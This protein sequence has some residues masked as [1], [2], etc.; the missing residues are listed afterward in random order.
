MHTEVPLSPST[1]PILELEENP[2]FSYLHNLAKQE[3]IVFG[4]FLSLL[5][6][7]PQGLAH[8]KLWFLDPFVKQ[9]PDHLSTNPGG[10][11]LCNLL[12]IWS[13]AGVHGGEAEDRTREQKGHWGRWV[14]QVSWVRGFGA[15][16]WRSVNHSCWCRRN[17][18]GLARGRWC[19]GTFKPQNGLWLSKQKKKESWI[20]QQSANKSSIYPFLLIE[21]PPPRSLGRRARTWG[22]STFQTGHAHFR[23]HSPSLWHW[24][25]SPSFNFVSP[26]GLRGSLHLSLV[27]YWGKRKQMVKGKALQLAGW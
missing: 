13:H 5:G 2:Y 14:S 1:S 10:W 11:G 23:S 26:K 16:P 4:F 19:E 12:V 27:R 22:V 24:G 9:G 3:T 17:P 7:E 25:G 21:I 20:I 6:T 8:A 15:A 18:P